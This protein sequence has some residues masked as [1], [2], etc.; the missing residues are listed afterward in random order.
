MQFHQPV[1][2][3][4]RVAAVRLAGSIA[5]AA[6][7]ALAGLMATATT[8]PAQG[9]ALV[10]YNSFRT[11]LVEDAATIEGILTGHGMA[12]D[13][14]DPFAA[15]D[16]GD[17]SDYQCVW[18]LRVDYELFPVDDMRFTDYLVGGGGLY[19]AGEHGVFAWRNDD[20][21]A[22]IDSLGGG[23]VSVFPI[24]P[25]GTTP[26]DILQPT[27]PD[28][29]ITGGCL[30]PIGLVDFSG[31]G[32]GMFSSLGT[33]TWL[34]GSPIGGASAAWDPG[35]LALAPDAHLVV[36]LDVNYMSPGDAGTLYFRVL[37]RSIP[38]EN[39]Q[40]IDN[41]AGYL[42]GFEPPPGN[43]DPRTHGYWHRFC[44]G[45]DTIDPGRNGRGN[46]PGPSRDS[47]SLPPGLLGGVDASLAP[48]G[49]RTCAALDDGSFSEPRIA[50]LREY[51]TLQLNI[52][53]GY[54]DCNVPIELRPVV[55]TD[56]LTVGDA[57]QLMKDALALGTDEALRDAI[58][59]GEHV[60]NGEAI[61]R[62]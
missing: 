3:P 5:A 48:Y 43:E 13:L 39:Y 38:T 58:W 32:C 60:N 16:L 8:V 47:G 40:F 49:V 7:I 41:M 11:T 14:R 62:R 10:V 15:E 59:I 30:D 56:G 18:D 54:L 34:T 46:G 44:L 20:V 61:L 50:A 57:V 27:N 22:L 36:G 25:S 4:V 45:T 51:A 33:G 24:A 23:P 2:I 6:T 9:R 17:L 53:A 37:N 28:H 12:V 52:Q 31:I 21:A 55:D 1:R 35:S 19:L 26:V 42:C 29:P